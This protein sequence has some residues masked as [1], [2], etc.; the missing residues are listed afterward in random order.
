MSSAEMLRSWKEIARYLGCDRKTC[1]RWEA[2]CGLPIKRIDPASRRSRVFAYPSEI[3]QWLSERGTTPFPNRNKTQRGVRGFFVPAAAAG[4]ILAAAFLLKTTGIIAPPNV[5]LLAVQ[6]SLPSGLPDE[7]FFLVEGFKSE[8]QRRLAASG[9][10]QIIRPTSAALRK[11]LADASLSSAGRPD[12][13][14]ESSLTRVRAR[15][16]L[17]VSL[18]K[19]R[20][21]EVLWSGTYDDPAARL[22]A[23]LDD[24][25]RNVCGAMKIKPA[26]RA[27][28]VP[29]PADA[30]AFEPYLTGRLLLSRLAGDSEDP[31]AQAGRA[32]YY[33][34]LD[35]EEANELAFKLFN[36]VLSKTPHFAPALLGLAQCYINNVNL[37]VDVDL[38]WLDMA[39]DKIR[40]AE[41]I[42]PGLPDY[43]RLRIQ[44]LLLRDILD[45]GDRSDAYFALAEA[46]LAAHPRDA[47]LNSIVGYGWFL[48]FGRSGRD[49]DFEQALQFKRRAF[50]GDPGSAAN[51]VL[52]ELLMLR[53]DFEEALKICSLIQPG[54]NAYW[55]DD[56]RAEIYFYMGESDRSQ[57][58]LDAQTDPRADLAGRYLRGMIAAG[59]GDGPA[60]RGILGEIDRLHPPKGSPFVDAIWYASILAGIGD[61][62]AAEEALRTFFGDRRAQAMRHINQLYVDINPNFKAMRMQMIVAKKG[63]R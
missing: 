3:D 22:S 8:L 44:S 45:G 1:A 24:V 17:A 42:E 10:L 38:R 26:G 41:S 57:A 35:D 59:R 28:P 25:C 11:A 23:C 6:S 33:S 47:G 54:P 30:A 51:A 2:E 18:Q 31:L 36:Q 49:G 53:G 48:E 63:K 15:S 37:G 34:Q 7:D 43:D 62:A 39:E 13:T 55:L 32:S 58:I 61:F 19:R 60:A 16:T 56:R 46:G 52:A 4:L 40:R 29:E 5:P 21:G 50:W 12:Y 20:G 27:V 14:L 9:R